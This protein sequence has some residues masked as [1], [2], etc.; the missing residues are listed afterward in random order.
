MRK[1]KLV[2]SFALVWSNH[3]VSCSSLCFGSQR[4]HFWKQSQVVR[5][6]TIKSPERDTAFLPFAAGFSTV[7]AHNTVAPEISF[8]NVHTSID[9]QTLPWNTTNP[10][11]VTVLF[12]VCFKAE[13]YN[14][15]QKTTLENVYCYSFKNTLFLHNSRTQTRHHNLFFDSFPLWYDNG[16]IIENGRWQW[17]VYKGISLAACIWLY[18]TS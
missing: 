9:F 18:A 7:W 4:H 1:D 10:Y 16:D 2:V 11:A 5:H 3:L 15:I 8:P 12:W 14:T 13:Q 17:Q 6:G